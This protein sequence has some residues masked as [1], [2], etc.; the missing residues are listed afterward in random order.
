MWVV[1]AEMIIQFC[2][3][4]L[5]KEILRDGNVTTGIFSWYLLGYCFS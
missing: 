5:G 3:E 1:L 4:D 2:L